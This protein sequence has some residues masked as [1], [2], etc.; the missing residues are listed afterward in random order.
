VEAGGHCLNLCCDFHRA[1]SV[2]VLS[3]IN[4]MLVA[5]IDDFGGVERIRHLLNEPTV[6]ARKEVERT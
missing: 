4:P 2:R 6:T 5:H 3:V 1:T